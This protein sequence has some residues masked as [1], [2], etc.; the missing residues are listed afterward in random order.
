MDALFQSISPPA[1]G[2]NFVVNGRFG[3]LDGQRTNVIE[4]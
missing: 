4:P 1:G 3:A 2:Q